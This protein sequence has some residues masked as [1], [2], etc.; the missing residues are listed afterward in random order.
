MK[1]DRVFSKGKSFAEC[2]VRYA[3]EGRLRKRNN[4]ELEELYSKPN[5]VNV[6]PSSRMRWAGHVV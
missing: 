1:E 2:M 5:I 6:I 3:W 4:R